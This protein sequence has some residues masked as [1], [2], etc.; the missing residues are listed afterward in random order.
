MPTPP[1]FAFPGT[2]HFMW[3]Q[4][5]KFSIQ[6]NKD[7]MYNEQNNTYHGQEYFMQN[8]IYHVLNNRK[9]NVG[10]CGWEPEEGGRVAALVSW[11]FGDPSTSTL[12][13][14]GVTS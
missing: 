4:I 2:L 13:V 9:Y 11:R 7:E 12:L 10:A 8:N 3:W 5:I 1:G 6:D 14:Q